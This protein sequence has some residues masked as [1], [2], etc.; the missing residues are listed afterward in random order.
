MRKIITLISLI[1][2]LSFS[3]AAIA[4]CWYLD[5]AQTGVTSNVRDNFI[6]EATAT[7]VTIEGK[8]YDQLVLPGTKMNVT[9]FG[10]YNFWCDNG[11][12]ANDRL[13]FYKTEVN[14]TKSAIMGNGLGRSKPT[15]LAACKNNSTNEIVVRA[16]RG[17]TGNFSRDYEIGQGNATNYE[18]AFGNYN[19]IESI[20]EWQG[21]HEYN[22]HLVEIARRGTWDGAN[23]VYVTDASG[24]FFYSTSPGLLVFS[25]SA[26][27]LGFYEKEGYYEKEIFF[28]LQSTSYLDININDYELEC[29]GVS[30][31]DC[32][33]DTS[34]KGF[35]M[36]RNGK[37]IIPG[38]IRINKKD[39][40]KNVFYR[41]NATYTVID[42]DQYEARTNIETSSDFTEIEVGYLDK[43][44]FQIEIIASEDIGACV[45]LDGEIGQTGEIIAPRVNT[46]FGGA[47]QVLDVNE[48]LSTNPNFVYCSQK[49]FITKITNNVK[50]IYDNE[51]LLLRD[52]NNEQLLKEKAKL[53]RFTINVRD[54][55]LRTQ[56]NDE[57][58]DEFSNTLFNSN[59]PNLG[60]DNDST[61]DRMKSL[62]SNIDFTEEGGAGDK[63]YSV[64]EY[65]VI[66]GIDI[67]NISE[68]ALFDQRDS[69]NSEVNLQ[70]D[71][72]ST[73]NKPLYDWFFYDNSIDEIDDTSITI[74]NSE[75]I[76]SSNV[77]NR[78][79]IFEFEQIN[80]FDLNDAKL[81]S[82]FAAPLFVKVD[83]SNKSFT[84][85]LITK[86]DGLDDKFSYWS[87]FA[88]N[89]ENGTVC[90]EL[91][92]T[93]TALIYRQPD[94]LN[95]T[96]KEFTI[97]NEFAEL[98]AGEE[99]LE[100]VLFLPEDER[101]IIDG[102]GNIYTT[103]GSCQ[104]NNTGNCSVDIEKSTYKKVTRLQEMLDG[105]NNRTVCVSINASGSST[106]WS[107]F[108]NEEEI[109]KTL[110]DVK[111]NEIDEELFCSEPEQPYEIPIPDPQPQA[112]PEDE[113]DQNAYPLENIIS[114]SDPRLVSYWPLDV[115]A[116]DKLGNINLD[117]IQGASI[118]N[119]GKF[120]NSIKLDGTNGRLR[121]TDNPTT[122]QKLNLN[123]FTL[124][125]WV[126][127]DTS[128]KGVII[129][130][131]EE[132][133]TD[134]TNF[135]LSFVK[136]NN[137]N[138]LHCHYETGSAPN[139][140]NHRLTYPL[141]D[142]STFTHVACSFE[143]GDWVLYINGDDVNSS[144]NNIA[145][146]SYDGRMSIGVQRLANNEDDWSNFF[147]GHIDDVAI[148]NEALSPCE[149]KQ[150]AKGPSACLDFCI[151]QE[152][153]NG[154]DDDL[155]GLVDEVGNEEYALCS[156][157]EF[158]TNSS[159]TSYWSFDAADGSDN[160][161]AVDV[162]GDNNGT[163]YGNASIVNGKI[164]DAFS[165][166]GDGDYII[167]QDSDSLELDSMT[168]SFWI[169]PN[170]LNNNVNF[171]SRYR[172]SS[173]DD[174]Y[175]FK[176]QQSSSGSSELVL[177]I[178]DGADGDAGITTR[179][180]SDLPLEDWT[181]LAISFQD[182]IAKIYV[183]GIEVINNTL[184]WNELY[185]S[186]SKN[187]YLGIKEGDIEED[188]NGI[189]D[190]VVIWNR[191]LTSQE[192]FAYY[193]LPN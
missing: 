88:S 11:A 71:L 2:I 167:I 113:C 100:T 5:A 169:K 146:P 124:S 185:T 184:D 179:A 87:G 9:G 13:E 158:I 57:L 29:E 53:Q 188:Y 171:I 176:F 74:I 65:N 145:L 48:C 95:S 83:Q 30:N 115:N 128:P 118:D 108:W 121:S 105:I 80:N 26:S 186:S 99:Y 60:V 6:G 136:I 182:S 102:P 45:G 38:I 56:R 161:T 12:Q 47:D 189:I 111:L 134:A 22:T 172:E 51:L 49:E 190:E 140:V 165:F 130:K 117:K 126:Q 79:R 131:D 21:G 129:A 58:I 89:L 139:E 160:Q 19:N 8:T 10:K 177:R 61:R 17:T 133:S 183:N 119:T 132:S 122:N 52:P 109:L 3:F 192:I 33:V 50:D 103:N 27:K 156:Y 62:F 155:D 72:T 187:T 97:Y 92:P 112:P 150:L 82:S 180:T 151:Q 142:I 46:N 191:E 85:P 175:R 143:N 107:I 24:S 39:I 64:G 135:Y 94:F 181:H 20:I 173:A 116:D 163:T 14:G 44:D 104:T 91:L 114:L 193:N 43:Q 55:D 36:Q 69:L 178:Y 137:I 28:T 110:T 23:E 68:T 149:I 75:K 164:G 63:E 154:I 34:L 18:I 66:I 70:I 168:I 35:R 138:H 15:G 86:D 76:F 40:P 153:C 1:L 152:I 77:E 101:V 125:A 141:E 120:N 42:L 144:T 147:E 25:D 159:P 93:E 78:G 81:Y 84:L 98:Q 123:K 31:N 73:G 67:N 90:G 148:F 106:D 16:N 59:L 37:M 157:R 96:T 41:L 166:D 127:S 174:V 54:L 4:H 7:P 170:Q 32:S 162:I